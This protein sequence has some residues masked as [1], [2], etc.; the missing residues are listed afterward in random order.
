MKEGF[1][2][3]NPQ[4]NNLVKFIIMKIHIKEG[5]MRL[6][7]AVGLKNKDIISITGAGGKTA[8]MF[9]LAYELREGYKV[10]ATT[11]TKIY[12][13]SF[14][15]YKF[16][17]TDETSFHEISNREDKGIYVFGKGI[18]EENKILGLEEEHL[19]KICSYFDIAI[20][21]ADGAKR[22]PLKGWNNMEPV[23]YSETT[24]TVGVLDIS[25]A[26]ET[27]CEETVH[28]IEDFS[29]ITKAF[30]GDVITLE[31]LLRLVTA[32]KGLFKNAT[33]ERILFI[34]KVENYELLKKAKSLIERI[35]ELSDNP[36]DRIITGSV[37]YN[38][39]SLLWERTKNHA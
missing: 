4:L 12:V 28:R 5:N 35:T 11:T 24:K 32:S 25:V 20:I 36:V 15:Q 7:Y 31:H 2:T 29:N 34:N 6:A 8:F 13:P 21:E 19:R 38:N 39:Y 14:E 9:A 23:I 16:L 17:C 37:K 10:L 1:L 26:G 30:T 27:V 3:E 18:N 22:K 33:G